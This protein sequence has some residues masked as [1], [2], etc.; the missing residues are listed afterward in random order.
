MP[1]FSSYADIEKLAAAVH[2]SFLDGAQK[3]ALAAEISQRPEVAWK[4][5]PAV[6]RKYDE[7]PA[8]LKASNR[9]AARRV[10]ELLRLINFVVEEQQPHE[11]DSWVNPLKDTIERHVDRLARG[12][13]LGWCAERR[14]NGWTYAKERNNE[15]KQHPLLVDWAQLTEADREK[16]RNAARSIP[17]WLKVA[18]FKAVP[19]K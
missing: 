16:D 13:H 11:N 18:G 19:A 9:A 6:M 3:A 10:P 15:R 17:A 2:E 1:K 12:E 5:H 4:I 7:L 14:D 8:D